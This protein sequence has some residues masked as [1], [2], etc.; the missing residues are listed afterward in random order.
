[1][2]YN[3]FVVVCGCGLRWEND[4]PRTSLSCE[5]RI[6]C[7]TVGVSEPVGVFP[8]S[9]ATYEVVHPFVVVLRHYKSN[10]K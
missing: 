4:K 8:V 10:P 5:R 7:A 2:V 3:L 6:S 1:M 9:M